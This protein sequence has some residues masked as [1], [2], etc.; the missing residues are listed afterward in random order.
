M[1]IE[2]TNILQRILLVAL[3][4]M[5]FWACGADS[6]F[7]SDGASAYESVLL[8]NAAMGEQSDALGLSVASET[9]EDK[10]SF[11]AEQNDFEALGSGIVVSVGFNPSGSGTPEDEKSFGPG[12]QEEGAEKLLFQGRVVKLIS[13][14]GTGSPEDEKPA[15]IGEQEEGEKE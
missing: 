10:E 4:P 6:D 12:T 1:H 11:V 8:E 3:L 7:L 2:N 15:G 13:P 5:I 14:I 9:G